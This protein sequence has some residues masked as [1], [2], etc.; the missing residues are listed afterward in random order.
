MECTWTRGMERQDETE[1]SAAPVE[2]WAM[3]VEWCAVWWVGCLHRRGYA[4]A[5]S[6]VGYILLRASGPSNVRRG[7]RC[8][9]VSSLPSGGAFQE[10]RN[11]TSRRY[12]SIMEQQRR[13]SLQHMYVKRFYSKLAVARF[14]THHPQTSHVI[15]TDREA[16]ELKQ[17]HS[18]FLKAALMHGAHIVPV[19]YFE[20][21]LEQ[22]KL[23]DDSVRVAD[24]YP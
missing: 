22:K 15:A 7:W 19:A 12:F 2:E 20:H 23:L 18:M 10:R 3:R 24:A 6:I 11:E 17:G 1:R 9:T 21:C 4:C 5:R 16:E 14:N 13:I 8:L